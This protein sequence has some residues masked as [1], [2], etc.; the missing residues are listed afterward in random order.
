MVNYDV[1]NLRHVPVLPDRQATWMDAEQITSDNAIFQFYNLSPDGQ[2]LTIVYEDRLRRIPTSGGELEPLTRGSRA[3]YATW[4]PDGK[5][6]YFSGY[7]DLGDIWMMDV[8]D[9]SGN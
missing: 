5:V 1:T 6:F 3:S 9:G 7:Q 4:A 8:V 2:S